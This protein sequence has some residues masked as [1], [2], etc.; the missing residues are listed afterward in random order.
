MDVRA[1]LVGVEVPEGRLR[2]VRWQGQA[3]YRV[4]SYSFSV[5]WNRK[6]VG[7]YVRYV[8]GGFELPSGRETGPGQ[9]DGVLYSVLGPGAGDEHYRLLV[10]DLSLIRSAHPADVLDHLLW[11]VYSMMLERTTELLLIHAGSLVTPEGKG[12]LLPAESGGGKTTL[13]TALVRA[14]FGYLSDEV[15]AVDPDSGTVH[16]YPRALNL[17]AG[18]LGLFP[19]VAALRDGSRFERNHRFIRPEEIRPGS[20][21]PRSR[22]D[23]VIAP[24]YRKGAHTALSPLTRAAA[25]ALLWNS[26]MNLPAYRARALPLLASVARRA[27]SYE[28]VSGDLDEAVRTVVRVTGGRG[29][30]TVAGGG[31]GG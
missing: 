14:G 20:V 2:H 5:R 3:T 31:R 11:H 21:V 12:V 24:R 29:R 10:G 23:F 26:C 22:V 17:K 18:S 16:A 6:V 4:L 1:P 9:P 8:L 7:E 13:V 27:R 15:A 25:I 30:A 19:A 28:L